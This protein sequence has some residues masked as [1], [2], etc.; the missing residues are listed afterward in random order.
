MLF[1]ITNI[2]LL[3]EFQNNTIKKSDISYSK[4]KDMIPNMK[5]KVIIYQED[6]DDKYKSHRYI[7]SKRRRLARGQLYDQE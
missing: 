2:F 7:N 1:K 6:D 5:K 4:L 3:L